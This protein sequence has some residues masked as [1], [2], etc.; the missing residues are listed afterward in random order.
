MQIPE[1]VLSS[2]SFQQRRLVIY[3]L[4]K[5]GKPGHM[6]RKHNEDSSRLKA[7]I[8]LIEMRLIKIVEFNSK[9]ISFKFTDRFEKKKI[10]VSLG[11]Y[12]N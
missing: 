8:G 1:S 12:L 5:K 2:M 4:G 11:C 9:T 6:L 10:S 7:L 3:L